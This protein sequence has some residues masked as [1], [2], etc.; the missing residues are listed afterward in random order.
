MRKLIV[1]L[2]FIST[3]LSSQNLIGT[4]NSSSVSSSDS[5]SVGEIY[6][7][8]QS[9][10]LSVVSLVFGTRVD[11]YDLDSNDDYFLYPNPTTSEA[12]I[13]SKY[14]ANIKFIEIIDIN[15]QL[16]SEKSDLSKID[17]KGLIP[18]IYFVMLN[19]SDKCN[20]R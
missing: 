4:L 2:L 12:Y 1:I 9:G 13:F 8:S 5:Y 6:I 11:I 10:F 19:S 3:S 7:P 20:I 15:G 18:G 17:L 14:N 16:L